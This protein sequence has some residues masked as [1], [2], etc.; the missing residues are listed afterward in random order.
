MTPERLADW[1]ALCAFLE[2][3]PYNAADRKSVV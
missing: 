1:E 3:Q 2:A